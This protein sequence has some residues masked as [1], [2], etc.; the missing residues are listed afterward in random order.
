MICDLPGRHFSL[1]MSPRSSLRRVRPGPG[2]GH[3]GRVASRE[4]FSERLVEVCILFGLLLRL[5]LSFSWSWEL[6]R[7]AIP[8]STGNCRQWLIPQFS[9]CEN[10]TLWHQR[11]DHRRRRRPPKPGSSRGRRR[12]NAA[13]TRGPGAPTAR[14]S[15]EMTLRPLD[16]PMN[17]LRGWRLLRMAQGEDMGGDAGK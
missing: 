12:K 7:F 14:R 15:I 6:V 16:N 1:R 3:R 17:A 10:A 5:R 11:T 2:L 13:R 4:R 9:L 8:Q